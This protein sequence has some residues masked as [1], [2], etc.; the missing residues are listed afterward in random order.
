MS[1]P[2]CCIIVRAERVDP[3]R[4]LADCASPRGAGMFTAACSPS[5]QPP[6]THY[7]SSGPLSPQ[8]V[9][10][11]LAGDAAG[12]YAAAQAGAAARGMELT[13]TL[14]DALAVLAGADISE[15]DPYIAMARVGVRLVVVDEL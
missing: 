2:H 14:D 6:A 7:I 11:L 9:A 12:V 3:A 8:F 15:D 1:D 5:G 13:A 4:N 10:L